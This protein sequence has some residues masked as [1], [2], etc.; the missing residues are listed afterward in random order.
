MLS[1]SLDWGETGAGGKDRL[2]RGGCQPR[3]PQSIR[4]RPG[5]GESW[6][7]SRLSPCPDLLSLGGQGR[8]LKKLTSG[9]R[10]HAVQNPFTC[11]AQEYNDG[12]AHREHALR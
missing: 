11:A 1:G 12:F 6:L 3:I 8:P 10:M 7:N 4:L 5:G 2:L 9:N